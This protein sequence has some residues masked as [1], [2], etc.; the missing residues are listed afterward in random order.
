MWP[1]TRQSEES[2]PW[3]PPCV[4]P[5]PLCTSWVGAGS[6]L[7]SANKLFCPRSNWLEVDPETRTHVKGLTKE[8]HPAE[9]S[10]EGW[11]SKTEKVRQSSEGGSFSLI[12]GGNSEGKL[13]N[14]T[15]QLCQAVIRK[16]TFHS[17]TSGSCWLKATP[18][19][20]GSSILRADL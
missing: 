16:L 11:G 18:G 12:P 7:V 15:S 14:D 5:A 6:Q 8:V 17:L 19:K 2:W 4:Y 1:V 9:A 3:L 10:K 13:C 20:V